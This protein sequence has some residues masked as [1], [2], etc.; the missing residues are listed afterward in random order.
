[1]KKRKSCSSL[2]LSLLT[3]IIIFASIVAGSGL[4]DAGRTQ[5][6]VRDVIVEEIVVVM[7]FYYAPDKNQSHYATGSYRGD[8]ALNGDGKKTKSGTVPRVGTLAA[9][10]NFLRPKTVVQVPGFGPCVVQDVGLD[11][12]GRHRLDLFVGRGEKALRIAEK[13]GRMTMIVKV[14]KPA[15][16]GLV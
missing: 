8:V 12:K 11:I 6:E 14:V 1:M 15:V 7:T 3:A 2:V 9:D 16:V 4:M 5:Q 13:L 10:P